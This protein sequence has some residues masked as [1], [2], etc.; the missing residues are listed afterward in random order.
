MRKASS[1]IFRRHHG[2]QLP[3]LSTQ[4]LQG[5]PGRAGCS[6]SPSHSALSAK[7]WAL[8]LRHRQTQVG[9]T[10]KHFTFLRCFLKSL[11]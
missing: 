6:P 11:G 10:T 9:H 4:W 8:Y 7:Q 5:M 2:N 1:R 3:H